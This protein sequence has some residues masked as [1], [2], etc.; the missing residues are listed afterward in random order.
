MKTT[1][2]L[3]KILREQNNHELARAVLDLHN[4]MVRWEHNVQILTGDY[5]VCP[6]CK[7]KIT[8]SIDREFFAHEHECLGCSHVR[9]EVE[10]DRHMDFGRDSSFDGVMNYDYE[11]RG[12]F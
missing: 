11:E 12:E 5:D 1:T 8:D 2:Q 10:S 9:Y 3:V 7:R 6:T 4:A